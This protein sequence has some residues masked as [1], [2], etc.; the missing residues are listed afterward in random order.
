MTPEQ[1]AN[2]KVGDRIKH[3]M[4]GTE[5]MVNLVLDRDEGRTMSL[6]A[7]S[8]LTFKISDAKNWLLVPKRRA[9]T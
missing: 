9:R 7:V 2:L 4:A 3:P 5:W 8:T 6:V 1:F